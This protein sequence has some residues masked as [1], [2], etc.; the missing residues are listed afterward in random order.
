MHSEVITIYTHSIKHISL[1]RRRGREIPVPFHMHVMYINRTGMQAYA[2]TPVP[3]KYVRTLFP[4]AGDVLLV[5]T[6]DESIVLS[7]FSFCIV[8][9]YL[10]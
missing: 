5:E 4:V 10:C 8:Y 2:G 7:H 1:S 9:I 3:C 6:V